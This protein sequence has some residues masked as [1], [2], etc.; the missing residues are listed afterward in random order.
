MQDMQAQPAQAV[1]PAGHASD[2]LSAG[3]STVRPQWQEGCADR[4][5]PVRRRPFHKT[6]HG[7][8]MEVG[9]HVHSCSLAI[10]FCSSRMLVAV[11]ACNHL[12]VAPNLGDEHAPEHAGIL[13]LEAL[14]G[15]G[16]VL[17][18]GHVEGP[19]K[20]ALLLGPPWPRCEVATEAAGGGE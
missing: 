12:D 7:L 4:L 19:G 13:H 8:E 15:D 10:M 3:S 2:W 18:A 11:G 16:D 6:E 20:G 5:V 17:E 1:A 9:L 14:E